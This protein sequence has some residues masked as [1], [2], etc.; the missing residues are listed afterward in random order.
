MVTE[1]AGCQEATP[2]VATMSPSGP[3]E[4][5]CRFCVSVMHRERTRLQE[6]SYYSFRDGSKATPTQRSC[7]QE[8]PVR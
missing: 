7:Y 5:S 1:A 4:A 2:G 3:D 8:T 6:N